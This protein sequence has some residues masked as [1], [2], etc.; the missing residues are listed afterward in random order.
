MADNEVFEKHEVEQ[1]EGVLTNMTFSI[2]YP[3]YDEKGEIELALAKCDA[4]LFRSV[5][6]WIEKNPKRV[7][8]TVL[9]HKAV[10]PISD[11][12]VAFLTLILLPEPKCERGYCA[13]KGAKYIACKSPFSKCPICGGPLDEK[14]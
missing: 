7:L 6:D 4:K 9:Y 1:D 11:E 13:V 10:D 14:P 2:I 3:D 8:D 12:Y 5:A